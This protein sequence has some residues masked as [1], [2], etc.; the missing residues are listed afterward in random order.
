FKG[1]IF[2]HRCNRNDVEDRSILRM[3]PR[4]REELA[5]LREDPILYHLEQATLHWFHDRRERILTPERI[6]EWTAPPL[7]EGAA[8]A[9]E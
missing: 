2:Y 8:E 1:S 5:A 4:L 9:A 7:D 3:L 6:A